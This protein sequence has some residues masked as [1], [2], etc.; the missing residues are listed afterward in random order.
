MK[1]FSYRLSSLLAAILFPIAGRAQDL[2]SWTESAF[3]DRSSAL[4]GSDFSG[5]NF[6]GTG[7]AARG[8]ANFGPTGTLPNPLGISTVGELVDKLS[9]ALITLAVPVVTGMIIWGAWKIASA[10]ND[11]KRFK[12]GGDIIKYAAIGFCLLLLASGITSIIQSLFS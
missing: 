9:T 3:G 2:G 6:S 4:G 7:S 11:P 1:P 10:G 12:D 5:I 8:S